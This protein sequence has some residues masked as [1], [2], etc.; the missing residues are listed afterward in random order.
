MDKVTRTQSTR[1]DTGGTVEVS[2]GEF[3]ALRDEVAELA[4]RLEQYHR[5]ACVIRMLEDAICHP[6]TTASRRAQERPRPRHL[7]AVRDDAS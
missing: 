6:M 3:R 5:E 2:T 4:A 7:Q 1:P